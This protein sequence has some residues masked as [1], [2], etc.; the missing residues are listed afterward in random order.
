LQSRYAGVYSE[1]N[2][3]KKLEPRAIFIAVGSECF[4]G[5]SI[6]FEIVIPKECFKKIL[7]KG[8]GRIILL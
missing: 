5:V 7:P 6:V 3:E 2:M 1:V 8:H 4:T